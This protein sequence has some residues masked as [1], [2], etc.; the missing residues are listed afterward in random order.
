MHNLVWYVSKKLPEKQPLA[1][2]LIT[3]PN[4]NSFFFFAL[5]LPLLH[6]LPY[7]WVNKQR[8][9][10]KFLDEGKRTSMTLDKVANLESIDFAWAKRKGDHSWMEKYQELKRYKE[11]HGNCDVPTKYAPSPSLGRWVSTQRS[12]YKKRQGGR[13]SRLLTQDKIDRLNL[14]GFTWE[15]LPRPLDPLPSPT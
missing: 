8:M 15:M 12:E 13:G 9:E 2:R 5:S 10:K 6:F 3:R 1:S 7:Q 11:R 14:L 4:K